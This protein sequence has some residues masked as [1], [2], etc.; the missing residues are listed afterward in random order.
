MSVK[1]KGHIGKIQMIESLMKKCC[2]CQQE[3]SLDNFYKGTGKYNKGY[4]CKACS[5]IASTDYRKNNIEKSR[6]SAR[7]WA[8]TN[9]ENTKERIAA[10][11]S[12]NVDS[13]RAAQRRFYS[14][15]Q[16]KYSGWAKSRR[17]EVLDQR[18]IQERRWRQSNPGK[19]NSHSSYRRARKL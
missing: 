11:Q 15:N 4:K 13:V 19:V 14:K 6:Q 8:E 5:N 9:K 17:A 12:K 1:I 16:M 3:K 18:K 7:K 10:W 2:T